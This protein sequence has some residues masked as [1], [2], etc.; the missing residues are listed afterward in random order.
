MKRT[1]K[2]KK[3]NHKGK[4]LYDGTIIKTV[5]WEENRIPQDDLAEMA[6]VTSPTVIKAEKGGSTSV[7]NLVAILNALGLELRI[8]RKAA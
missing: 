8:E 5:R 4:A 2:K 6:G 3:T 1:M 7:K